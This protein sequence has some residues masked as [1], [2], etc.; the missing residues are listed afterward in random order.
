[1]R[2]E[3]DRLFGAFQNRISNDRAPLTQQRIEYGDAPS[4]DT[5]FNAVLI[6]SQ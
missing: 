5:A 3:R 1:M 2:V 6:L 4:G